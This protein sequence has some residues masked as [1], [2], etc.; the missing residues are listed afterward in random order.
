MI[1]GTFLDSVGELLDQML[2]IKAYD[3]VLMFMIYALLSS[4]TMMNMLIGILCE[5]VTAVAKAEKEEAAISLIKG[6]L[7]GMLQA[8]AGKGSRTL[9]KEDLFSVLEDADSLSV[10]M[11]L[12]VSVPYLLDLQQIIFSDGQEEHSIGEHG[13]LHRAC[14]RT[15]GKG[16]GLCAGPKGCRALVGTGSPGLAPP[17]RHLPLRQAPVQPP[18]VAA[19][20]GAHRRRNRG[21]LVHRAA[22]PAPTLR[23]ADATGH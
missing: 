3:T 22:R 17:D 4:M 23:G 10:L 2:A 14:T 6:N 8:K 1:S 15:G 20:A 9:T 11:N 21:R 13:H 16:M 5:V 12:K 19:L 18:C 7:L